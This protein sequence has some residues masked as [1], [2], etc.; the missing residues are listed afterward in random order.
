[1]TIIQVE[2][3]VCVAFS[4]E[5]LSCNRI[6]FLLNLALKLCHIDAST[7]LSRGLST[8]SFPVASSQSPIRSFDRDNLLFMCRVN[9]GIYPRGIRNVDRL[10]RSKNTLY[11]SLEQ[12]YHSIVSEFCL[13]LL[14]DSFV[15]Y[16][17]IS[18]IQKA[19]T[20]VWSGDIGNLR[21]H[22]S[23]AVLNQ[24]YA[25][26]WSHD[27]LKWTLSCRAWLLYCY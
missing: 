23:P 17:N 12:K 3:E 1:M 27:Y 11:R 22:L 2:I 7:D 14:E 24:S 8:S 21:S 20:S 13:C 26:P 18:F 16:W 4:I 10:N 5:K 25:V 15:T 9:G 19:L 6:C